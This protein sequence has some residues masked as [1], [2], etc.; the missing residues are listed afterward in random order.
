MPYL[1]PFLI[2]TIQDGMTKVDEPELLNDM[3]GFNGQESRH[4][5]C[6][7][8]VNELLKKNG[9]PELADVERRLADSYD[10]RSK[11]SLRTRLAFAAG[12]ESMTNGFTH[13]LIN[14][15]GKL[16]SGALPISRRSGS[17]I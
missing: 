2:K 10:R 7:R 17:C 1:E 15:R 14:K 3:R 11:T 8:R 16:F 13:W 4:Y 9:Y 5:Q 6:H 12:F